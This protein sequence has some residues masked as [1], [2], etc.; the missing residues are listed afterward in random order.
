MRTKILFTAILIFLLSCSSNHQKSDSVPDPDPDPAPEV[1]EPQPTTPEEVAPEQAKWEALETIYNAEKSCE[2]QGDQFYCESIS[3]DLTPKVLPEYL[4]SLNSDISWSTTYVFGV[5]CSGYSVGIDYDWVED[6][7]TVTYDNFFDHSVTIE[8]GGLQPGDVCQVDLIETILLPDLDEWYG[9]D[10]GFESLSVADFNLAKE[11]LAGEFGR[12]AKLDK[13]FGASY[14]PSWD[15]F[16]ER[17]IELESLKIDL[18][19]TEL[20]DSN[21]T[22]LIGVEC[23]TKDSK[24]TFTYSAMN[25]SGDDCRLTFKFESEETTIESIRV[26]DDEGNAYQVST[27]RDYQALDQYESF[28]SLNKKKSEAYQLTLV[29]ST[30][31]LLE[32]SEMSFAYKKIDASQWDHE[33][34]V[35]SGFR[36]NDA[37]ETLRKSGDVYV[38]REYEALKLEFNVKVPAGLS[39][40][41]PFTSKVAF[42]DEEVQECFS[43][44]SSLSKYDG[45]TKVVLSFRPF[46]SKS[47]E[48]A[49]YK[50]ELIEKGESIELEVSLTNEFFATNQSIKVRHAPDGLLAPKGLKVVT[51]EVKVFEKLELTNGGIEILGMTWKMQ[52]L[53]KDEAESPAKISFEGSANDFRRSENTTS[54]HIG[55]D[56]ILVFDAKAMKEKTAE[57]KLAQ[58]NHPIWSCNSNV[59]LQIVEIYEGHGS[60][61][62]QTYVPQSTNRQVIVPLP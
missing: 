36:Y 49:S 1:I 60:F 32:K 17:M 43:D 14:V 30:N 24:T 41:S 61:G 31:G 29:T 5:R 42:L 57:L 23:S 13:V 58:P 9:S 47:E 53:C 8:A 56:E 21:Q 34:K 2:Q 27:T 51:S 20:K 15:L 44:W 54:E 35:Y 55:I 4:K 33:F 22:G 7:M 46:E 28:I 10:Y 16:K 3:V 52:L 19:L 25:L 48:C 11:F 6:F 59:E 18:N 45:N 37:L 62:F 40:D 26:T 12:V 39:W 38:L 50:A